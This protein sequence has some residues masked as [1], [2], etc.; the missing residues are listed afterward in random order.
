MEWF[1]ALVLFGLA[2]YQRE[3][4]RTLQY[5]VESLEC[6]I[7]HVLALLREGKGAVVA[8]ALAPPEP[9]KAK[10]A[11]FP[12]V[13]KRSSEPAPEPLAELQPQPLAPEPEREQQPEEPTRRFAFDFEELFGRR[14]PIWAGGVTL[15]VAGVLLVRYSIEAGLLTPSVRVVLSFLFGLG[16]LG[17]AEAAYRNAE[18]VGD[19]RVCQALAGAGLAT[20]YAGF[21]LAGSQYDLIGQTVAFLGLA[22]VTAAAIGL[23]YRFGLPSAVLGLVGGFAAPALVGGEEANLPLLALYL[24]LVT[25]GLTQTGNRQRRPWLGLGALI[26]GL[27]WGGLLLTTGGM[28]GVDI[29]A[30]GLYSVLLGAVLPALLATEKLERPLRLASAAI[31]SL[32][33]AV[34]VD[35]GGYSA[36]AWGLYLLL[37]GA[38]AWFGW[39]KPEVRPASAMAA[40]IGVL[41]L[42]LWPAPPETGF[43]AV[44]AALAAIFA[45]VPLFHLHTRADQL[46]DRLSAALVPLALGI[47]MLLTF[48]T[49]DSDNLR[50]AEALACLALAALPGAAAWL[51][52]NREDAVSLAVNLASAAVLA[53]LA[54]LCVLPAMATPFLLGAIAAGFCLLLRRRLQETLPLA[55]VAWTAALAALASVPASDALMREMDALVTG[56]GHTNLTGILRW[57]AGAA[58]FALL[59]HLERDGLRRGIAEAVAALAAFAALAQVLPPIAL[60]WT[61]TAGVLALRWRIPQRDM[62]MLALVAAIGLWAFLPLVDWAGAGAVSLAGDPFLL[63]SLPSLR[64]TLGHI[65]P[66]AVALAAAR[67]S[68]RGFLKSPV[69]LGWAALPVGFVV[70]HVLFKQIFAIETMTGFRAAGLAERTVFEALLLALGWGS[71]KGFERIPADKRVATGLAVLALAH[72]AVFT[73]FWHNPL[74]AL[75]AVG[76]IP[77]ANLALAAFTVAMAGLLSLRLWHPRWRVWIDALVMAT[78]TLGAIT[79]LRQA[80]AGSYLPQL[81]MSQA[82]DLLRSLVGI[83]L[84]VAF[85]LIGS[86]RAERSWRVGSLVLMTGTAIKVFVFDTAGLEGLVRIASFVALGASLIGI[87]WFYS[88]QLR[89]EPTP[90]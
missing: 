78:A 38:L 63:A 43:A 29:L 7:D 41:L 37:G 1:L 77:L 71:A 72:F 49:L 12:A 66:L 67:V 15:A 90:Q 81:P 28:S 2:F 32:Q 53:V 31:A 45:G 39:R 50:I 40:T 44:A 70:L 76:P 84:A 56:T 54:G 82:E 25:G 13:V 55:A 3:K 65:L 52:W 18:R 46:V 73:L 69:A 62:A 33:L 83:V 10:T 17:G 19:E 61:A 36:L 4:L 88:R 47:T 8:E 80:F 42:G 9:A 64:S 75:Q 35:E 11:S 58:P 21:Y 20:L 68:E 22:V 24:A 87:G 5:R 34:L 48:G 79:L 86:R 16:L 74:F 23:S 57:L 6:A 51:L 59:A 85:L 26:G 60:V 89:S 27:G 14:L 30:L